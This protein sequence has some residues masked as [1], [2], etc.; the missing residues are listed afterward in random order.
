LFER[1]ENY[2]V[3]TLSTGRA[4]YSNVDSWYCSFKELLIE[5]GFAVENDRKDDFPGELL[6]G[7]GQIEPLGNI[8]ETGIVI[9][10]PKSQ[11]SGCGA[12]VFFD[13]LISD[14]LEIC[15]HTITVSV[16]LSCRVA[17]LGKN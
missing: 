14:G 15:Q 5:E 2:V 12:V 9:G 3:E 8:N 4:R 13:P 7:E 16:A 6:H 11:K 17:L 10:M 1:I